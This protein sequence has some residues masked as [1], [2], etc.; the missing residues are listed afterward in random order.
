MYND[1]KELLLEA[2]LTEAEAVVYLELKQSPAQNKWEL[3]NRTGFN[4]NKVYRA[5]EKLEALE[6]VMNGHEGMYVLSLD[7]LASKLDNSALIRK[8]KAFSP[9]VKIP[10]EA[11]ENFEVLTEKSK[12]MDRYMMMAE[13]KYDTCLDF[14]DLEG[15]VPM[16]GGI[17][18]V[19]T[20]RRN[21][22]K[23]M[24]NNLALCTTNGPYTAC[25]ARKD[26]MKKYNADIKVLDFNY[27]G[28][29]T[30]FSDTG[31]YVMFNDFADQKNSTSV[32]VKSKVVADS[33]RFIFDHFRNL[34]S[35]A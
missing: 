1:L 7:A 24:A 14:G 10:I 32:I 16:L 19:F 18:K 28:R 4:R 11:V 9:F 31:N 29:W 13:V 30:I 8:I 6:L 12:F 20:F 2:G 27:K 3:V 15:F 34:F 23:Q 33:Q 25:M 21:R 5:F 17:D 26:D 22:F 35:I